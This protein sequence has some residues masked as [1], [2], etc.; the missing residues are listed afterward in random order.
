MKV[1]LLYFEVTNDNVT[2]SSVMISSDGFLTM[3]RI[4]IKNSQRPKLNQSFLITS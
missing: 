1:V 2:R 4:S 3:E